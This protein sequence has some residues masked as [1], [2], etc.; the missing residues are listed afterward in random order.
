MSITHPLGH[1]MLSLHMGFLYLICGI[2]NAVEAEI[3]AALFIP[4]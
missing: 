2:I 4:A 3:F 1:H